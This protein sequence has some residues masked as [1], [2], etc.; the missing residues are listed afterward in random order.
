MIVHV[1]G[2]V[3]IRGSLVMRRREDPQRTHDWR[4]RAVHVKR[5]QGSFGDGP[6]MTFKLYP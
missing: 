3:R 1:C 2:D 5:R 4:G 6:T